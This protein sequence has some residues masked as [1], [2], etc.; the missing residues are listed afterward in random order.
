MKEIYCYHC[1]AEVLDPQYNHIVCRRCNKR[2]CPCCCDMGRTEHVNCTI[3]I[4]GAIR[5]LYD[6]EINAEINWFWDAGFCVGI[7]DEINGYRPLVTDL[8]FEEIGPKLIE[9][10]VKHYQTLTLR[11]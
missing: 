10:A 11:R 4:G 2:G 9:E 3:T 5:S 1:G 7:G 8:E 6:S